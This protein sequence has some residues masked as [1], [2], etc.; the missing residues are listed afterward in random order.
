MLFNEG[1]EGL[2]WKKELKKGEFFVPHALAVSGDMQGRGIGKEVITQIIA[3]ARE[4]NKKGVRLDIVS[5]NKIAERLYSSVG[6]EFVS[7]DEIWY[8]D[9]GRVKYRMYELNF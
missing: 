6:F 3:L 9:T 2:P 5:T 4:N 8:I 7:E 1:Y